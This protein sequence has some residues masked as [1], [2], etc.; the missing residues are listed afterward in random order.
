MPD[1]MYVE[2]VE[3][4]SFADWPAFLAGRMDHEVSYPK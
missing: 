2:L 1:G 3:R 4:R